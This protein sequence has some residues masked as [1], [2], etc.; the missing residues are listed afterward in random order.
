M[1]RWILCLVLA[2]AAPAAADPVD[3]T[4]EPASAAPPL[5][6]PF[7]RGRFGV[8]GYG[9]SQSSLDHRYFVI[10]AGVGYY[11]LDGVELGLAAAHWFGSGPSISEV[12]PS[13]RYVVQPLVGTW[14]LIPYVGAFYNH[15]FVGDALADQDTVGTRGGLL[16]VSG[17]LVLGLGI[18]YERV[19]SACTTDCS[20][21]YP[22][23]TISLA[24]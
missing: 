15:V 4:G 12:A 8:T 14:P 24:L 7:D 5:R 20:L 2:S 6:T 22:D 21:V 1:R 9:G 3:G 23:L 10:G 17:Q 11:V 18:A 13:V 19:V 16:Y